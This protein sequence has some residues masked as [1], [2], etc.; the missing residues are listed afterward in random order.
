MLNSGPVVW[1]SKKQ[2]STSLS[3]TEAEF[4]ASTS[5]TQKLIWLTEDFFLPLTISLTPPPPYSLTIKGRSCSSKTVSAQSTASTLSF[6]TTLFVKNS[7]M[8]QLL[9]NTSLQ[10][11]SWLMVLPKPLLASNSRNLSKDSVSL[12][13]CSSSGHVVICLSH[14]CLASRSLSI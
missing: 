2:A 3:S 12:K 1:G 11:S 5:A 8:E 6:T 13:E 9:P 4:I 10:M 14:V 7:L